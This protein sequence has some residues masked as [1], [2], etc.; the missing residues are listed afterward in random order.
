MIM[1]APLPFPATALLEAIEGVAY[2]AVGNGIIPGFSRGP[3]LPLG[4]DPSAAS[5]DCNLT[6]GSSL[7][8]FISSGVVRES[9]QEL[10]RAVWSGHPSSVGF[11][12]RCDAL[13]R[14]SLCRP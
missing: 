7:F 9:Y 3:F 11:V 4:D 12:Y 2:A 14:H 5:W 8:S 6:V 1:P 13:S 10:H